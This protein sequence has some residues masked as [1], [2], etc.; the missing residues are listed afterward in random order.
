MEEFKEW[1][2]KRPDV[3]KSLVMGKNK[4][5]N[6]EELVKDR[7]KGL[8]E[9]GSCLTKLLESNPENRK[10]IHEKLMSQITKKGGLRVAKSQNTAFWS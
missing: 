6:G 10:D 1:R 5:K 7:V 4:Q 8:K 9:A 2:E 3:L